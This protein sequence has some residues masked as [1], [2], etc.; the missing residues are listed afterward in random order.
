MTGVIEL[1]DDDPT[2]MNHVIQ[3]LYTGDFK[4]SSNPTDPLAED[5]LLT[6]TKV[7]VAADK[8]DIPG[9]RTLAADKFTTAIATQW[10]TAS[11]PTCLDFIYHQLPDSDTV[12]KKVALKVIAEHI[13]ELEDR[14]EFVAM[15]KAGGEIAFDVLQ[16]TS[17]RIITTKACNRCAGYVHQV[18]WNFNTQEYFCQRCYSDFK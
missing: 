1:P 9:L 4:D 13:K 12:L 5:S 15:F 8:Y 3:F 14:G 11:L 6:S 18:A 10:N 2:I 7:Y 17:S 16:A